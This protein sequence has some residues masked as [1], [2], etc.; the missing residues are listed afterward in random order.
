MN[1]LLTRLALITLLCSPMVQAQPSAYPVTV[2]SCDRS[3]TFTAA[4][5]RA[6]SNDVNLTKM[7]V[8]LGLQ[9]HMVGYSGITGWNKPDQALLRDLGNLPELA[10]RKSVV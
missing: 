4:P 8:A 6:V 1:A 2:Q 7:M 5:Q 10:D 9:S 3:V